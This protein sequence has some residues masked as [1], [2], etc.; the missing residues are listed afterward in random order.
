MATRSVICIEYGDTK[1]NLYRHWDG[2]ISEGG[3]QLATLLKH[4]PDI[5]EFV[6]ACLNR[7]RDIY[8][9]DMDRPLYELLDC[10]ASGVEDAEYIYIIKT[11]KFEAIKKA[12]IEVLHKPYGSKSASIFKAQGKLIDVKEK[13]FDFCNDAMLKARKV[14]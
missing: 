3:Y 11:Q 14:A 10:D 8:I 7:Q 1:V 5:Q 12:Y 6:K 9:H 13:F 2:Y 4:Y